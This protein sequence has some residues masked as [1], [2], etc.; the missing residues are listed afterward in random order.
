MLAFQYFLVLMK[1]LWP[2]INMVARATN[3]TWPAE[4]FHFQFYVFILNF[5]CLHCSLF[6]LQ[7]QK[8]SELIFCILLTFWD[9][10]ELDIG[11]MTLEIVSSIKKHISF[12]TNETVFFTLN[13]SFSL[14]YIWS[15]T[16]YSL[17][18]WVICYNWSFLLP[19]PPL[20][21]LILALLCDLLHW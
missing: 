12:E 5:R 9:V 15:F 14:Q 17:F 6:L 20:P 16:N 19:S 10:C 18:L 21:I 1:D 4:Y 7:I 3:A 13:M 2:E 11:C 8:I